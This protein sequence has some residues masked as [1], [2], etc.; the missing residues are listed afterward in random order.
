MQA[1]KTHRYLVSLMRA[2]MVVQDRAT[3]RYD[4]GPAARR[5][6]IQAL[7]RNHEVS[8]AAGHVSVLRNETGPTVNLSVWTD[9][10]PTLVRWDTGAHVLPITFRVGSVLPILESSVGRA[11]LAYLPRAD[12][13]RAIA[14]QQRK[15]GTAKPSAKEIDAIIAEVTTD[16]VAY[17]ARAILPGLG[18]LAAPVLDGDGRPVVVIGTAFPLHLVGARE[19]A[20]LTKQLLAVTRRISADLGY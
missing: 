9:P 6:G 16:G 14:E 19:R 2:G 20:R 13:R 1:N 7:R 8:I 11:F 18:A 3:G 5:L 4:L 17:T 12:T 15:Q 10:G